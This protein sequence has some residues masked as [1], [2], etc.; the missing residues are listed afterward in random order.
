MDINTGGRT[1]E[2][3]INNKMSIEEIRR[4]IIALELKGKAH[5]EPVGDGRFIVREE[6]EEDN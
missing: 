2:A 4:R 5:L 6:N 1:M 3:Y